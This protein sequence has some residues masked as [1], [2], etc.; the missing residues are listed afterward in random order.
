MLASEEFHQY[1]SQGFHPA[2]VKFRSVH[3]ADDRKGCL[4]N[5]RITVLK[6]HRGQLLR[7]PRFY[8]LILLRLSIRQAQGPQGPD[9]IDPHGH[10]GLFVAGFR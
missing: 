7:Y 1:F 9:G 4:L 10:V 5:G 3:S 6:E 8:I 2:R